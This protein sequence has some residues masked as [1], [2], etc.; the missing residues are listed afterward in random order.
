MVRYDWV[1]EVPDQNS[2]FSD[3]DLAIIACFIKSQIYLFVLIFVFVF[4]FV[5]VCL[6]VCTRF[7]VVVLFR[8]LCLYACSSIKWSTDFGRKTDTPVSQCH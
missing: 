3:R 6:F 7:V 4:V 2:L 5:F 1:I 8:G